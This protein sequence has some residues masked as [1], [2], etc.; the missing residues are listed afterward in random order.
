MTAGAINAE[1]AFLRRL[2]ALVRKE[3]IQV[4]RDPAA[5]MIAFLLPVML[6]F[7]FTYAISLDIR[8][9]SF[10]VVLEGTSPEAHE[11][12]AAYGATPYLDVWTARHHRRRNSSGRWS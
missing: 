8:A 10:G 4:V 11:L 12:A 2:R 3:S 6:L 9:I 5:L 1:G 7:L